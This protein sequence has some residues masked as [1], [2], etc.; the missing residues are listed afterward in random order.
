MHDHMD[1]L[2]L[3]VEEPLGLDDFETFVHHGC[4]V[5]GDLRPHV[6]VGVLQCEV[7]SGRLDPRPV[8]GAERAA[9]S[10][11][12]D[13]RKRVPLRGLQ[14]LENGGMLGVHRKD[15]HAVLAGLRHDDGSRGDERL[16]IGKGD[17]F[18]GPDGGQRGPEPAEAHHRGDDDVH[19]LSCHQVAGGIDAGVHFRGVPDE[20]VPHRIVFRHVTDDRVRNGKLVGLFRKER[21]VAS[22]RDDFHLEP[23]RMLPDHVQRLAAD[24][25]RRPEDGDLLSLHRVRS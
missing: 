4:R 10:R 17:V 25:S 8:P 20:G 3:H 22:R 11:E 19:A 23:V 6:P 13:A 12:M 9:R 7:L 2:R 24:G 18:T 16:F 14:A 5:D 15:L 21:G 1:P